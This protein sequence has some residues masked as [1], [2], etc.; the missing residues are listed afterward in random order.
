MQPPSRPDTGPTR[1]VAARASYAGS[2]RPAEAGSS[3]PSGAPRAGSFIGGWLALTACV[4]VLAVLTG[5]VRWLANEH[6]RTTALERSQAQP[7]Y[8]ELAWDALVPKDWA[9]P[10]RFRAAGIDRLADTD[11]AAIALA[12]QMREAWDNAPTNRALDGTLVRLS[13]YVVP[14]DMDRGGMREFLLVPYFGACIH[15]P[16]P[17]ANQLVHVRMGADPVALRSM[18]TVW[19]S[20]RLHAVRS[21]SSMGVSG[22]AL[23][24]HHVRRRPKPGR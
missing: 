21:D 6:E 5:S 19:V 18:D 23:D 24:A 14:L 4:A 22:Y 17:A 9:P 2:D 12:R 10:S 20:G 8:A 7:H 16:A 1:A 13:G 11:P 15:V 3:T